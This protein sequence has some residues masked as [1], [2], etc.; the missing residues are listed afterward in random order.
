MLSNHGSLFPLPCFSNPLS[1]FLTGAGGSPASSQQSD[2]NSIL[3]ANLAHIA[4]SSA[5]RDSSNSGSVAGVKVNSAMMKF[6]KG[7]SGLLLFHFSHFQPRTFSTGGV[8]HAG[9]MISL[10]SLNQSRGQSEDPSSSSSKFQSSSQ[11]S[12][13]LPQPSASSSYS[14]IQNAALSSLD[15]G[16]GHRNLFNKGIHSV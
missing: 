8:S 10:N 7:F 14:T 4:S 1:N 16:K 9:S 3:S 5:L 11:S 15:Q 12:L 2:R 13:L 6:L